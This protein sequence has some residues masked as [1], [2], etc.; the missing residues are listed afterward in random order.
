MIIVSHYK[1][2]YVQSRYQYFCC[3]LVWMLHFS[4]NLTL[5][6]V[7]NVVVLLFSS[8]SPLVTFLSSLFVSFYILHATFIIMN[9]LFFFIFMI[10]FL[11]VLSRGATILLQPATT[12]GGDDDVVVDCVMYIFV[13][14]SGYS[15]WNA[16]R[17][18]Y[19]FSST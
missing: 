7:N 6:F 15:G 2:P 14:I 8:N 5:L 9:L 3:V 16:R 12:G 19:T 17:P 18:Y 1:N 10:F 4:Q 13:V 11:V